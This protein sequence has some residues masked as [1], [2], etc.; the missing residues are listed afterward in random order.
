MTSG[1][2]AADPAKEPRSAKTT[3]RQVVALQ[4]RL[5]MLQVIC[6]LAV[7]AYG[8]ATLQGFSSWTSIKLLLVLSSL[9]GLASVGQTLLIL[10]GG[11]DMSVSGFIVAGSLMCTQVA[12]TLHISFLVAFLIAMVGAGIFGALAAQ[13]CHRLEINPLIITLAMGTIAVGLVQTEISG[14]LTYGSSAP[15]WLIHLCEP[16]AKTFGINLPPLVV[17]WIV[18]AILMGLFLHRTITGR[19]LLATGANQR[20]AEYALIN[21]RRVWTAAFVFSA[22]MSVLVGLAVAGFGGAI[23]TGSGDPYLF[24]S[25]VAVIVGGTIFGGPGDYTRTVIGALFLTV[26]DVVLVGHGVSVA[27]QQMVL[28]AAILISVSLYSRGR[29]LRD[30]I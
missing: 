9:A 20:G 19:R 2:I 3:L 16:I 26:I 21:T 28:G 27:G 24:Q 12:G 15:N 23:T 1:T 6:V 29:K 22:M 5:P 25:V 17:I 13:I 8:A 11:F 4:Q 30:R 18:V 10:I 7:F 14:G